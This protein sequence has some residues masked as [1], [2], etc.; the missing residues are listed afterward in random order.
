MVGQVGADSPLRQSGPR[1]RIPKSQGSEA[2]RGRVEAGRQAQT[3]Q[4]G[5]QRVKAWPI[6]SPT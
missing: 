1:E 2:K 5:G 6:R 4:T 3:K